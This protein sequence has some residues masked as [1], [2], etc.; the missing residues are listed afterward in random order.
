MAPRKLKKIVRYGN[1]S[2]D[3]LQRRQLKRGIGFWLLFGSGI[4]IVIDGIYSGWNEGLARGA[5]GA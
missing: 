5:F 4:G 1:V 2:A 3:Y